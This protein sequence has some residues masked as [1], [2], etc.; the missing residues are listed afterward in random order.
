MSSSDLQEILS[1][2]ANIFGYFRDAVGCFG[3][4]WSLTRPLSLTDEFADEM[5]AGQ[6]VDR[7]DGSGRFSR[8][9]GL[10]R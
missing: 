8:S 10:G 9:F 5:D 1:R 6:V 3:M 2:L 7:I 4:L